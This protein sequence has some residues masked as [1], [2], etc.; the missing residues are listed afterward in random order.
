MECPLCGK[1]MY[2]TPVDG[3]FHC[4]E[5]DALDCFASVPNAAPLHG[6]GKKYRIACTFGNARAAPAGAALVRK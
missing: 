4:S 6:G 2:R 5:Q 3:S 1:P